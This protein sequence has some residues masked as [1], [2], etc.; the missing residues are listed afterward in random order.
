MDFSYVLSII[1]KIL[2]FIG[3]YQSENELRTRK[4]NVIIIMADDMGFNDVS[5]RGNTEIP[6]YNIDALAFSGVVLNNF[7]T[8]PMCT[9]SRSALMTGKYPHKI[10]MHDFVIVSNEPWGLDPKEKILPQYF[11]EAGYVTRLV[12]KW[13]LGHFQQQYTPTKRHFDSF[14]GY[15]TGV[16][17]YF[18]H[19]NFGPNS[20]TGLDFRRNLEIDRTSTTKYATDLFTEEAVQ[21][22]KSHNKSKP[23]YLQLNHL[24]PHSGSRL[25]RPMDVK[26]EILSK[27]SYIEDPV[28]RNLSAMIYELDKS[29]GEVIHALKDNDMLDDSIII[30]YNDN[31]CPTYGHFGTHCSNYPLRGQKATAFEGGTR[32]NAIIYSNELPKGSIRN[33]MI[34]VSDLLPTLDSFSGANFKYPTKIDGID[35]TRT[36]KDENIEALRN[37]IFTIDN[38][39]YASYIYNNKKILI[40]T[41]FDGLYDTHLGANIN[42]DINSNNYNENVVNSAAG[43][44]FDLKLDQQQINHFRKIVQINC[45]SAEMKNSCDLMKAPCLFDL[46]VDPCEENNLADK[47]LELLIEMKARFDIQMTFAVESRRQPSDPLADPKF[48]DFTWTWWQDDEFGG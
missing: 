29:V 35:Q 16:I 5:F 7:K 11:K 26:P 41:K 3:F 42:R 13:H 46:S 45:T 22:I 25:D 28:R 37:E 39:G 12:G 47:H 1:L 8:P 4:K 40:G 17:D 31:G 33:Q 19:T 38:Q 14:F 2:A 44:A 34:H 6:T 18:D 21:L 30:F 23:L 15:L 24:A 10:G 43:K 20:S 36:L 27:F 9:P 48:H 32:T